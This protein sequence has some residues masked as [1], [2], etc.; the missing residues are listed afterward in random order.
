VNDREA[1]QVRERGDTQVGQPARCR[2]GEPDERGP[3]GEQRRHHEH[4][5]QAAVS[6]R[7]VDVGAALGEDRL[8]EDLLDEYRNRDL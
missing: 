1:V 2:D 7:D 4:D 8:V 3:L 6:H 5:G